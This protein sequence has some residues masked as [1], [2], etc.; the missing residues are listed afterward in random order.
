MVP[1]CYINTITYLIGGAWYIYCDLIGK[2]A[3]IIATDFQ[4]ALKNI[5]PSAR[6]ADYRSLWMLL[7]KII[8]DVGN[9]F[10]YT[11]TFLCLYLFLVITLTVYGLM[12]QI[13]E[14]L[15]VKD[16]GLAITAGFAVALLFFICDE[17]H[18]AS[19]CVCWKAGIG[20]GWN[21][22]FYAWF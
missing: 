17:A 15:G 1:Y 2:V 18:Y 9:S 8:R 12:S 3:T 4:Q 14:G 16:I 5:G 20:E 11:L 19:N 7:S 21:I 10:G 13:Q 22:H 6:V